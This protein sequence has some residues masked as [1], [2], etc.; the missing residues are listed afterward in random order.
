MKKL[1]GNGITDFMH[2]IWNAIPFFMGKP[3]K[4]RKKT[5]DGSVARYSHTNIFLHF[6][7]SAFVS[8]S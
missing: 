7:N 2:W 5:R 1:N 8:I 3:N 4:K 6:Q